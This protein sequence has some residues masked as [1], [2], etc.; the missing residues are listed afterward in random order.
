MFHDSMYLLWLVMKSEKVNQELLF[1]GF[2]RHLS[3]T[4]NGGKYL[5]KTIKRMPTINNG[6]ALQ[7]GADNS[8]FN[9]AHHL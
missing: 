8:P 3:P 2:R 1:G 7:L 4:W 9:T 6:G 5:Q